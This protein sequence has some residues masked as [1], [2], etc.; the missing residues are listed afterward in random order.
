MS[1]IALVGLGSI[2]FRHLQGLATADSPLRVFGVDP[3]QEARGRASSEWA[4]TSVSAFTAAT[5]AHE[6][7]E[8]IDIMIVA[9]SARGR[10]RILK[11]VLRSRR[12]GKVI[13]EKVAFTSRE[14]F[15][16]ALRLCAE[17]G[18]EAFVNC[19]RR[20][21]PLYQQ[22]KELLASHSGSFALH[23][24]WQRLGLACNGVHFI[25]LLQY[26]SDSPKVSLR[27][28]DF[29]E[30]VPSK[31]P[32][33]LEVM[34]SLE[35][36]TPGGHFIRLQAD[37]GAPD[38]MEA[39][40]ISDGEHFMLDELRG[41]L[42]SPDGTE[43]LAAGTPP[44]QSALTGK[45]VDALLLGHELALPR[46]EESCQAHQALFDALIPR[47]KAAGIDLNPGLPIT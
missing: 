24:A 37:N 17:T 5:A 22:L 4:R 9:T 39:R 32:G 28:K 30:I 3:D 44:F 13:L 46:L 35:V 7:P 19:P 31:R 23:Y 42:V 12:I 47:F 14:E 43:V 45:V 18:T 40:L 16:C 34:G 20:L 6:L 21:W 36:D 25:D 11:E 27:H 26:L 29:Q 2:G 10:L 15:D 38:E 33:Y 41:R 1:N 8:L